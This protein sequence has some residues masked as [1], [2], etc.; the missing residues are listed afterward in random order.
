MPRPVGPSAAT[1]AH[2][3]AVIYVPQLPQV[4]FTLAVAAVSFERASVQRR[5]S[6]LPATR[7][8]SRSVARCIDASA[9]QSFAQSPLA[10]PS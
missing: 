7:P 8:Q 4:A 6:G 5:T 9:L 3:R 10:D 2:V 1:R